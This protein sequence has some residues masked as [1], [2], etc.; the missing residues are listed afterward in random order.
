[1]KRS[2]NYYLFSVLLL[3]VTLI[4]PGCAKFHDS[5]TSVWS[6]IWWIPWVAGIVAAWCIYKGYQEYKRYKKIDKWYAVLSV[7]LILGIIAM[8]IGVY[9]S[10]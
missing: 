3:A 5:K 4:L 8:I 10:K 9:N 6:E 7:V 2:I 1:M